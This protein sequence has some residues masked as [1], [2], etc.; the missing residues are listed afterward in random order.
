MPARGRTQL[1]R[2]PLTARETSP[3]SRNELVQR[4]EVAKIG[5]FRVGVFPG[6]DGDRLGHIAATPAQALDQAIGG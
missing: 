6:L 4:L 3:V 5:T 1:V 2:L